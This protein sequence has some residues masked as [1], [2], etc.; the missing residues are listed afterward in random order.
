MTG[1]V[2]EMPAFLLAGGRP[3]DGDAMARMLAHAY[4]QTPNPQVAYIGTANKDNPAFF[5]MMKAMLTKAGARKVV[6]VKLAKEKA[7]V[8]KAKAALEAADVIFLSGGE[9]EDGMIWLKKHGLDGFLKELHRQGK[10][11]MGVSA[12][13]KMLG[14]YWV[15]WEIEGDDDTS[16][17]FTCLGIVPATFDV[18][19]EDEDWVELKAALKLLGD[20]ARGFGI[21]RGGM[22][23]ADG[24]GELA[25]IEKT[26]LTFVNDKGLI[27]LMQ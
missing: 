16:S 14:D 3:S 1:A 19:G 4:G 27:R 23:S 26:M 13:T 22:I 7:D 21:P 12:G 6:H 24:K 15:R 17:L 5:A 25:N 20:G 11:F 10:Q 8:A 18:H 2:V 9:V